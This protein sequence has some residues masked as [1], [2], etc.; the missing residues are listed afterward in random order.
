MPERDLLCVSQ[1]WHG[2]TLLMDSLDTVLMS[3]LQEIRDVKQII[4][5]HGCTYCQQLQ[6]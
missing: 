6:R 1:A 2:L 5:M 4:Q 3:L